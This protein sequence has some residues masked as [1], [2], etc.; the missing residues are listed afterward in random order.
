M[1]ITRNSTET[2][3]GPSDWFTGTAY[4]DAVAADSSP[5]PSSP[6]RATPYE[7]REPT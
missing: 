4:I 5:A 3:R 7:A 1:Q 2:G 6:S